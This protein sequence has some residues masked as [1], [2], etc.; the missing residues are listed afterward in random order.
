MRGRTK[1]PAYLGAR[2]S[3]IPIVATHAA[4]ICK[5]GSS[6]ARPDL[7]LVDDTTAS[8]NS[9]DRLAKIAP[10]LLV[11]KYAEG[12]EKYFKAVADVLGKPGEY[13]KVTGEITTEI[14]KVKQQVTTKAG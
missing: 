14:G 6:K 10:T 5:S 3:E 7:I 9:L 4:R 8:R 1:A 12:W 13:T 11:A 2:A